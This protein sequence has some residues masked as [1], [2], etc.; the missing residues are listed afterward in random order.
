MHSWGLAL[1]KNLTF[2]K[3]HIQGVCLGPSLY[4]S[5]VGFDFAQRLCLLK[6]NAS[7][8]LIGM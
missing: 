4:E 6:I 3:A 1:E 2:V 5:N 8:Q 7:L